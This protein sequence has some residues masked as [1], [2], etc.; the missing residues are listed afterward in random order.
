MRYSFD[1]EVYEFF[2]I[3][4]KGIKKLG[5]GNFA[6]VYLVNGNDGVEYAMKVQTHD[7]QFRESEWDCSQLIKGKSP[8]L[9]QLYEQLVVEPDIFIVFTFSFSF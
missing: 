9:V 6:I 7:E 8:Y 2:K 1:D 4:T 3:T 5:Q